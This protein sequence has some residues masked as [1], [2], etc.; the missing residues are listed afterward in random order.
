MEVIWKL[1]AS[2]NKNQLSSSITLHDAL[3]S[4]IQGIRT[5]TSNLGGKLSQELA[6]ICHDTPLQVLMDVCKVYDSL[7]R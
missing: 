6:R 1:Y 2:I 5:V 4:S 3:S 7:D